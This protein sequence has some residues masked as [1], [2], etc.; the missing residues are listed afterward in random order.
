MTADETAQMAAAAQTA[1]RRLIEAF[2]YRYHPMFARILELAR[3]GSLGSLRT[4]EAVFEVAIPETPGEIRWDAKLGGGAL[5]D[6][7]CYPVHWLRSVAGAEP[8]V[9]D[10]TRN[11]TP[12]GVDIATRAD[13]LFPNGLRA[14][15]S[16]S[17]RPASGQPMASLTLEGSEGRLTALNPLAPQFGHL[18]TWSAGG[19]P[20]AS[21]VF[22]KRPT[23]AYQLDA[24]IRAITT[25]EP[26]PT[27]GDDMIRTM[28]VIDAIR[29]G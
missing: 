10:V 25:G 23:Y 8:K 5:M 29:A 24:V 12:S 2:H 3:S 19:A 18:L 13:L 1:Q 20:E 16:C 7:G 28:Q 4:A 9:V 26:V 15:L 6:L 21:E 17:M 14:T 22:D 27:E 11:M